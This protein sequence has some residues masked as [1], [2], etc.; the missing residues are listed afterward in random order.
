MDKSYPKW[1]KVILNGK[2]L[3]SFGH[4]FYPF[5]LTFIHLGAIGR[6]ALNVFTIETQIGAV[7]LINY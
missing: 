5:G 6:G 4:N 1:K 7:W 3:C 2:T